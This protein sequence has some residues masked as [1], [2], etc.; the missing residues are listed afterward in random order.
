M[1]LRQLQYFLAVAEEG[2]F[3]RAA[4]RI[5]I[6]QSAV[7]QQIRRLER[8][9]GVTLFDRSTR[10][11]H[12]SAA[13]E[14]L[15][16]EA[17][18]VLDAA[19]RT[20]QV[21]ADITTG[22]AG[23]LR[24]GTVHGPGERLYRALAELADTHPGLQVRL[25]RLPAAERVAAVREGSLDAALIRALTS[26]PGLRL[27]PLRTDLLYAALPARHPL[28]AEA[29]L[30]PEQFAGLPLRLAAR[31]RNP[32]FHDL[33][34]DALRAAGVTPPPAP[35]FTSL[36]ETL[37]EIAVGPPSWTVFYDVSGLPPAPGV[38][39]RPLTEPAVPTSLVVRQG[40]PPPGLRHLVAALKRSFRA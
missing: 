33:L 22:A 10:H 30:G 14:R 17:R 15:L 19:R 6:V 25:K 11:V 36:R 9:L 2:G 24:L 26:A 1:E 37:A 3:A 5:G 16:P 39:I 4:E 27:I 35:E 38:A 8:D 21:A 34:T 31:D 13:G 28:A 18:L 23:L 20:R 29:R 12:L 40:Q 7:S 32:P